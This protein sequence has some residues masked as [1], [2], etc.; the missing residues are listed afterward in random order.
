MSDKKKYAFDQYVYGRLSTGYGARSTPGSSVPGWLQGLTRETRVKGE[1][2]TLELQSTPDGE[3]SPNLFTLCNSIYVDNAAFRDEGGAR[4]FAFS[5]SLLLTE[6][7]EPQE[8]RECVSDLLKIL[9]CSDCFWD[10]QTFHDWN[11]EALQKVEIDPETVQRAWLQLLNRMGKRDS[12]FSRDSLSVFLARYWEVCDQRAKSGRPEAPLILLATPPEVSNATG[13]SAIIP[14]GIRFFAEDVIPHLPEAVLRIVSVSFGC[15]AGQANSQPGTACMVCYPTSDVLE[16]SQLSV[17]IPF[18]DAVYDDATNG[19]I[20]HIGRLMLTG[21]MPAY[22]TRLCG[23]DADR[24]S[25]QDFQLLY[26]EVELEEHLEDW[27]E[28]PVN[29]Q[30]E[31][32]QEIDQ[33][34]QEIVTALY[35]YGYTESEVTYILFDLEKK[36]LKVCEQLKDQDDDLYQS[37]LDNDLSL[38]GRCTKLS[39]DE[40]GELE[41]HYN[42]LLTS[43]KD[44]HAVEQIIDYGQNHSASL[45]DEKRAILEEMTAKLLYTAQR[46]RK[47]PA[48]I[49]EA[50]S[51]WDKMLSMAA[52]MRDSLGMSESKVTDILAEE[53][54]RVLL[55][56]P[57]SNQRY[58]EELFR[59]ILNGL[60]SLDSRTDADSKN[61]EELRSAYIECL[62]NRYQGVSGKNNP[63]RTLISMYDT[64][65]YPE[66]LASCEEEI[67]QT[68]VFM[69]EAPCSAADLMERM[70]GHQ[71]RDGK[72]ASGM[73][74]AYQELIT[75]FG[76]D[77]AAQLASWLEVSEHYADNEQASRWLSEDLLFFLNRYPQDQGLGKLLDPV[78][79]Q[80]TRLRS[81]N[82]QKDVEP[83]LVKTVY[84][85]LRDRLEGEQEITSLIEMI[86]QSSLPMDESTGFY[87]LLMDEVQSEGLEAFTN[88]RLMDGIKAYHSHMSRKMDTTAM[89]DA[90]ISCAQKKHERVGLDFHDLELMLRV[91]EELNVDPSKQKDVYARVFEDRAGEKMPENV[92]AAYDAFLRR[93]ILRSDEITDDALTTAMVAWATS[94]QSSLTENVRLILGFAEGYVGKSYARAQ[95]AGNVLRGYFKALSDH[96]MPS[97]ELVMGILKMLRTQ[98]VSPSDCRTICDFYQNHSADEELFDQMWAAAGE[99]GF[100]PEK[101]EQGKV[102]WPIAKNQDKWVRCL[103]GKTTD[104]LCEKISRMSPGDLYAQLQSPERVFRTWNIL[105]DHLQDTEQAGKMEPMFQQI[106]KACNK[107]F[108]AAGQKSDEIVL[109]LAKAMK[110]AGKQEK[111]TGLDA[112]FL[113]AFKKHLRSVMEDEQMFRVAV[114]DEEDLQSMEYCRKSGFFDPPTEVVTRRSEAINVAFSLI[115]MYSSGSRDMKLK[116]VTE[117]LEKIRDAQP[118][119]EVLKELCFQSGKKK[120]S[121]ASYPEKDVPWLVSC[122][123]SM[124]SDTAFRFNWMDF[125]NQAHPRPDGKTWEDADILKDSDSTYGTIAELMN[126]FSADEAGK[127]ILD[128]FIRFLDQSNIGRKVRAG[129]RKIVR[130]Y[131]SRTDNPMIHWIVGKQ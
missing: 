111:K 101:D 118:A 75:H 45:D 92:Q 67:C 12:S 38:R 72:E 9:A 74:Q 58:D 108:S 123:T 73:T 128:S 80:Y 85:E 60:V 31:E 16:G 87:Q 61:A 28:V 33:Q 63:L 5:Q 21:K 125:L 23:L 104:I 126:W 105:S 62:T 32:L 114:K 107:S 3:R 102:F 98:D 52:S 43:R 66:Q 18:E 53:E 131:D 100:N 14:D 17:Y 19:T 88:S 106:T 82:A 22:Y 55:W 115:E 103:F 127:P 89:S 77:G 36:Y 48:D 35:A 121:A 124:P 30:L 116:K 44:W 117:L 122:Y 50:I 70:L 34:R 93:N 79:E 78:L 15:L 68:A 20:L 47:A 76:R 130:Y 109:P 7:S 6:A 99:L 86:W 37:W 49:D 24:R 120:L 11:E 97:K 57:K 51:A 1:L 81:M 39:G 112:C 113:A 119:F 41:R 46:G 13:G 56:Y 29:E 94:E 65:H 8:Y 129:R 69:N 95:L 4:N 83:V 54:L 91:G 27:A 59:R 26:N 64:E 40:A 2:P 110:K 25:S 42:S 84:Q 10:A 71:I 90:F 96:G